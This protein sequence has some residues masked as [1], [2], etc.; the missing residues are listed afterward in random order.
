[1]TAPVQYDDDLAGK[2]NSEARREHPQ[3][4]LPYYTW[5]NAL[6]DIA[7]KTIL[8]LACGNG[9]TSRMLAARG[10][11]VTGVD[12]SPAQ[13]ERAQ[14][15]EIDDPLGIT[16]HVADVAKLCLD[17]TF[18]IVTP[19][20]LF[21]YANSKYMLRNMIKRTAAHLAPGGRMV[22]LTASFDPIVPRIHN[23]SHWT[24]WVDT[25]NEEGSRVRM[26]I[27]DLKGN[28]V[29]NF[30]YR[31]WLQDRYYDYFKQAGLVDVQEIK[32]VF[33]QEWREEFPNWRDLEKKNAGV[34]L[35]A[36]KR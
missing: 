16:Y 19:S 18:D 13:I 35:T 1:M 4:N 6:G 34:V 31:Y 5:L 20:F 3:S 11:T 15:E 32:H 2:Y 7:G 9:H 22:A 36:R 24:E 23:A 26:Y 30:V 12:I 25:A 8:D 28:E 14:S 21:H 10:A 29:C 33:P 27:C 17:R